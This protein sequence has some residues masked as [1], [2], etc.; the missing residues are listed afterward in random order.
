MRF[1]SLYVA[2]FGKLSNLSLDL[3]KPLTVFKEDNGWGKST[4]ADFFECMLYGMDGGRSKNVSDNVRLKYQ[5][6]F[7]GAYGGS[8]TLSCRGVIYRIERSFGKTAGGDSARVFDGNNMPCYGFGEK[9]EKFGELLLGISRDTYRNTAYIAQGESDTTSI[10]EDTKSKLISLLSV[11]G[12]EGSAQSALERLDVADRALRARRKPAKGKL[13]EVDE[14]LV[15]LARC[16]E[17]SAVAGQRAIAL[18][19]QISQI[20]N[21]LSLLREEMKKLQ[22]KTDV[23]V[24]KNAYREIRASAEEMK[25]DVE[26]LSAF[27]GN[28]APQTINTDGL[29]KAVDEY[30]AVKEEI[31]ET[32]RKIGEILHDLRE[33]EGVLASL[34]AQE[35]TLESYEMM[36]KEAKK[37]EEPVKVKVRKKGKFST[38]LLIVSLA[39]AVVGATQ[40]SAIPAL[41]YAL[42]IGGGVFALNV[43]FR[44][45]RSV[46]KS[47]G[48]S[49]AHKRLEESYEDAIKERDELKKQVRAFDGAEEELASLQSTVLEKKERVNGLKTG[50]EKFLSNFKF[51]EI[52]DY[53]YALEKLT[54]NIALYARFQAS[55]SERERALSGVGVLDTEED[56]TTLKLRAVELQ[57]RYTDTAA[58]R[59]RLASQLEREESVASE[60]EG[61]K[62]EE[63]YF[64]QE[65]ARLEKR[66]TA[67]RYAKELLIKARENMASKYLQP[68]EKSC[69]EYLKGLGF[70][71]GELYFNGEGQPLFQINGVTAGIDYYSEGLKELVGFCIRLALF[72]VLFE[73]EKPP[74]ILDD[75]FVNL[76]DTKTEKG[77]MLVRLLAEKYQVVYF[78]CKK[79][80][81]L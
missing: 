14:R 58:E 1:I 78:T 46:E 3:S 81:V 75:P 62:Q 51:G 49:G 50:I 54:E 53:R 29:K 37:E 32:E 40:I 38:L 19:E 65:K 47:G 59:A 80:R 70:S 55:L 71:F 64:E 8:L 33:R 69:R 7:G 30:Y 26:K 73:E 34:S 36:L 41:G 52:Y 68:V 43:L 42:F 74:L 6:I 5:P 35:K 44:V 79:E 2:G 56:V 20:D 21:R 13:D 31:E 63:A 76:D 17:N 77:K 10:N 72:E 48:K 57:N 67:I 9:A 61:Y 18:K 39:V 28:I 12:K 25:A 45:W 24:N 27:F 15:Y 66:L 23:A 16:R 60:E 4:L 11:S 22:E